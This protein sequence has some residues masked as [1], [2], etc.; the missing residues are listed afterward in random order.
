MQ[1]GDNQASQQNTNIIQIAK[2]Y[3]KPT[4]NKTNEMNLA[5]VQR[6][7]LHS[8]LNTNRKQV[9]LG[10]DRQRPER[11]KQTLT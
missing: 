4:T 10:D 5:S 1:I 6:A 8:N 2:S 3:R 9:R 7:H 11:D